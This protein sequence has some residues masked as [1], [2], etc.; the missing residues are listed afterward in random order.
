MILIT[1][2]IGETRLKER[3]GKIITEVLTVRMWEP[4]H[5]ILWEKKFGPIQEG[6]RLKAKGDTTNPDPANW[7][8]PGDI[9]QMKRE[10]SQRSRELYL[11]MFKPKRRA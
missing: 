7:Y 11:K 8:I 5:R 3:D 4:L 9:K 10:R 2:K 1:K 6:Y